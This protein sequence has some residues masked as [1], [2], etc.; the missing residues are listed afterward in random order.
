MLTAAFAAAMILIPAF[1]RAQ[2][3][4]PFKGGEKVEYIIHYKWATKAD[5]GSA[6]VSVTETD[7]AS[8]PYFHVH[9]DISTYKFWDTF[10]KVR[11]TYDTKFYAGN[12][13]P[14]YAARDAHEGDFWAKY[15]YSWSNGSK[16]LRAVV[17]KK[18]RPHRDTLFTCKGP[19]RDLFNL[20]FACRGADVDRMMAGKVACYYAAMDKDLLD[21]RIKYLGKEVKK[22]SG[23]GSF[24]AL[25]FAVSVDAIDMEK[26]SE[27]DNTIFSVSVDDSPANKEDNVFY[28]N[29]KIFIWLTDD[30]N[31]LPIFFTVPVAVGSL[32][33]RL[34]EFS[35]IK[36]PLTSKI[37]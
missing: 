9:T 7:N 24:N 22:V 13:I 20:F 17:D 2:S 33:G 4:L 21:I 36:Y 35:G 23:V 1:C 15:K 26:L 31:R 3:S 16:T 29:G 12:L 32:N 11:D 19:I 5:I 34:G 6:K 25:K 30:A 28:G 18:N 8:A 27:E 37:D 14:F 10:Y